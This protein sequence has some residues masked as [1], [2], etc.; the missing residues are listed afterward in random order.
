M[1]VDSTGRKWACAFAV[2]LL[3][4]LT[5]VSAA[6]AAMPVKLT[7]SAQFGRKVNITQAGNGPALE[8]ICTVASKDKCGPGESTE[9]PGGFEFMEG[10]ATAPGG[11]VYVVDKGH[12]RIQEFTAA[13]KFVL[14]FGW[15]V[16]KT[17]VEEGGATQTEL[18][19]CTETEVE[20]GGECQAG[21]AGD[22]PGQFG[23]A[24]FSIA[25]DPNS[26][27]VYVAEYDES[28][29]GERV[30]KFT[31]G[32]QYLYEIGKEVN[33]TT[34]G[35]LCTREEEVSKTAKCIGPSEKE[36]SEAGGSFNFELGFDNLLSV[37][38][39][40]VLYVGDESRVQ[41]FQANGEYTGEISIEQGAFID[42]LAIAASGIM[43]LTYHARG[44]SGK[45]VKV[46]GVEGEELTSFSIVPQTPG[47]EVKIVGISLDAEG[48]LGVVYK[49]QSSNGTA[50]FG[51]LYETSND[52]LLTS[53]KIPSGA[54]IRGVSFGA[55]GELYLVN[56]FEQ[57]VLVYAP[58]PV[59]EI[60]T[61]T[62]SC[63]PGPELVSNAGAT[64]NCTLNGQADPEGLTETEAWFEWGKTELLGN[65][66]AKQPIAVAGP[67]STE[68]NARPNETI[69]YRLAGEDVNAKFPEILAGEIQHEVTPFVGPRIIGSPEAP[70][71]HPSSAILFA[72]L[73][74]EN[75]P[76]EY[77]FEYSTDE[78]ALSK[79]AGGKGPSC[80]GVAR[81]PALN[82]AVY[83]KVGA[84]A[85]VLELQPSTTY[86]YR[87]FAESEG[88]AKTRLSS[89]GQIGSFTTEP[90]PMPSVETGGFGSVGVTSAVVSGVV[91]PDGA[92]VTY[93]F[94][95]GVYAGA[96]T[97]Y[98]VIA[99]G[100]VDPST[101]SAEVAVPLTGLQPG[102]RY[103][104][105]LSIASGY[106][107]NAGHTLQGALGTFVTNGLPVVLQ[108]P[109]VLPFL[110]MPKQFAFPG[111]T[112]TKK[113]PAK[114]KPKHK[115]KKRKP[116]NHRPG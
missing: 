11:N 58:E 112:S 46:L 42:A 45:T 61:G 51:A 56:S 104:Y 59:A 109:V 62:S 102:T 94:E 43:Y 8:D 20:A 2:V 30:Q 60:A 54:F 74:P 36:S 79:C 39:N 84:T 97:Q 71:L 34:K 49:Q 101:G 15:D 52:H 110:P 68:I 7:L 44:G 83:G 91:R 18:N 16:N 53:F 1:I 73:N 116:G 88:L 65:D 22:E 66:T 108:Q 24:V 55:N 28:S 72:Q 70:F 9:E 67:I 5:G 82:S 27:A 41:K 80:P 33:E 17:K 77:F 35:N 111:K 14:M 115:K 96:E 31:A 89:V 100:S 57:D 92:P 38:V 26:G 78:N 63:S 29:K 10:V 86:S 98:G 99:T 113:A 19:L 12:R 107:A 114:S 21:V 106:I 40:G 87:L 6:F 32:G 3:A 90:A 64:F 95:L 85:E 13:G 81:T 4:M 93:S 47:A 103:A 50:L 69:Y 75:A 25:V 105:R 37:D 76:S 23:Q 48:H